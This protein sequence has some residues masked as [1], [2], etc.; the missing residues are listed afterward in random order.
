MKKLLIVLV[1]IAFLSTVAY[2]ASTDTQTVY[3]E[4]DAINE[5]VMDADFTL[6]VNSAI[7]GSEPM[8]TAWW[9]YYA[10][11]T[12]DTGKKITAAINANM[13]DNTELKVKLWSPGSSTEGLKILTTTAQDMAGGIEAVVDS[14]VGYIVS[15]TA[16]VA[17][18]LPA[19]SSRAITFTL[20]DES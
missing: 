4:I 14:S 11:T 20:C 16:T 19:D 18:G 17:A 10:I 13:P 7:A 5:L 9:K 2:A 8:V 15:L 12:N 1:A 3:Y 6:T